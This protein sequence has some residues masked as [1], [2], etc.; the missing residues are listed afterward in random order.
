MLILLKSIPLALAVQETDLLFCAQYSNSISSR[1]DH[2]LNLPLQIQLLWILGNCSLL[3]YRELVR[4]PC[5]LEAADT[6][7]VLDVV[8]LFQLVEKGCNS[9]N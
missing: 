2:L 3:V 4:K 8:G 5:L 9:V 1:E 7:K 6:L